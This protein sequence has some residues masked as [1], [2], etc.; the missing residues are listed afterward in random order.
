M[1]Y[2]VVKDYITIR[3]TED[4]SSPEVGSIYEGEILNIL[5]IKGNRVR[6]EKPL[7]GWGSIIAGDGGTLMVK[8]GSVTVVRI[9][10]SNM[11][12]DSSMRC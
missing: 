4:R 2:L 8:A 7:A 11:S 6:I 12:V 3:K 1:Q 9:Y 5:E 10:C